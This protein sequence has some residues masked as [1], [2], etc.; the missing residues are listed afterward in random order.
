MI[1]FVSPDEL[2]SQRHLT[3]ADDR[4]DDGQGDVTKPDDVARTRASPKTAL[5]LS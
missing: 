4:A 3:H 1:E 2:D 5:S